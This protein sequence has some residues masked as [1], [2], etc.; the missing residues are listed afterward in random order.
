M[1]TILVVD[2]EYGL[3]ETLTELLQSEGYRVVSAANGQDGLERVKQ[4]KPDLVL[5]DFMMPLS[6]GRDLVRGIRALPELA[7][8]PVI[9]M[10]ASTRTVA[11]TDERGTVEVASFLRKPVAW[12]RL[13]EGI[14]KLIGPGVERPA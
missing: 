14:V 9:M 11:L 12:E 4:E 3:V 13:L 8:T 2:D 5:T 6:N 1:K 10:T 7:S